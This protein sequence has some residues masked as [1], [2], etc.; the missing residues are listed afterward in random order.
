LPQ[1]PRPAAQADAPSRDFA[2][3]FARSYL[4]YDA[5]R[6][7]ARKRALEPF[8]GE[9]LDAD[10]G[11]FAASGRQR[12]L[13]A[14]VSSD[15][16]ALVGGRLITVAAA[17]STQA[18]PLYLAVPV[19][20][21]PG[22]GLALSGYPALVGAPAVDPRPRLPAT[23][24]VEDTEV[25]AVVDRV[26][27]NYLAGSAQNLS[28]DLAPNATVT[29]PTLALSLRSVR[30]LAWAGSPGSGAVLAEVLADDPR[31]ATYTLSYEIGIARRERPYVHFIQVIPTAT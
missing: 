13:W 10:A 20:H 27:R 16:P 11:F 15:Q 17:V 6:P 18:L 8:V 25:T 31:R 9:A 7:Q 26:L 1:P 24:P 4:S 23:S 22:G 2:L 19:R 3:Q 29:L 30:Q 28:A 12:V 5:D 14:E 21:D